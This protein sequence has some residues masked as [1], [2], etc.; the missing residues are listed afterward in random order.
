MKEFWA[1]VPDRAKAAI[2]TAWMTAMGTFIP[3]LLGWMSDVQ[4]WIGDTKRDFPAVSP[5]GK[6]AA[7]AVA[8]AIAA[9]VNL[10]FRAVKPPPTYAGTQTK[11]VPPLDGDADKGQITVHMLLCFVTIV[12]GVVVLLFGIGAFD[13]PDSAARVWAG[14]GLIC[15]GFAG[16]M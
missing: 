8:G 1:K 3:A 6:V 14:V 16:L 12:A 10:A 13:E 5:L 15:A 11:V 7:A 4:E 9:V 2:H